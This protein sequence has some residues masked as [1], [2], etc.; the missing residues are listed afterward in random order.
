[1]LPSESVILECNVCT[2]CGLRSQTRLDDR[3]VGREQKSYSL[4]AIFF[5]LAVL[6][7]TI[8]NL[9]HILDTEISGAEVNR[10]DR[11]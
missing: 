1:M 4:T 8:L 5:K 7:I 10:N 3:K 2:Q 11:V 6:E 9:V